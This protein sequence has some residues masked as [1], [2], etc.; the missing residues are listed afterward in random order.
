MVWKSGVKE[1]LESVTLPNNSEWTEQHVGNVKHTTECE[2]ASY[3][4]TVYQQRYNQKLLETYENG[5]NRH[6]HDRQ[7][8]K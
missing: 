3:R 4:L 6:N 1:G 2:N 7:Y 8:N 5:N